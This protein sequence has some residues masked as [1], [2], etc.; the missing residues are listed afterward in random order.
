MDTSGQIRA[1][2]VSRSLVAVGDRW[3]LLILGAAFQGCVRFVDWSDR[4]GIA[5]NVLSGRLRQLVA[6]GCLE[7]VKGDDGRGH[8]YRLTSMGMGL[9]PTALMFWRFD[10]LW[11]EKRLLHPEALTHLTCGG[12]M[13]PNMACRACGERVHA[14]DVGYEDGPGAGFD[15]SPPSR[16]SRRSAVV[17][18]DDV[19]RNTLFGDSVD[20]LGDRWTQMVIST[21]FLGTRRFD[22]IQREC[23]VATNLLSDRLKSM[24][25][26]GM[27]QRRRYQ[28]GPDRFEY[29][30]T[31][32]GMDVYPIALAL[33]RWGD[34][35][36]GTAAGPPLL[37]HHLTCGN[38]LEAVVVCDQC[39]QSPDPHEVLFRR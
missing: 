11:S 21:L 31:P 19:S 7:M 35:W 24:V 25:A 27:L 17:V 12:S 2:S 37:L 16:V 36:L 5:S 3:S 26:G 32:R 18:D 6:L 22:Q 14:R 29:L 28:I 33:M 34:Q 20:Y 30:L 10:R 1:S 39:G 15:A 38:P 13:V 23:D 4:I 9:Y 8:E